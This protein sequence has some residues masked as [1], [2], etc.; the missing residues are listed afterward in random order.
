MGSC[1]LR[2]QKWALDQWKWFGEA[3]SQ[4]VNEQGLRRCASFGSRTVYPRAFSLC[5]DLI[6][7][8]GASVSSLCTNRD[9]LNSP[10]KGSYNQSHSPLPGE[11]QGVSFLKTAVRRFMKKATTLIAVTNPKSARQSLSPSSATHSRCPQ[12][13]VAFHLVW[14]VFWWGDSD[15]HSQSADALVALPLLVVV[16]REEKKRRRSV[17]SDLCT[18]MDYSPP[19]YSVHGFSR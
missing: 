5:T 17:V 15:L 16:R 11:G 7:Q 4:G 10:S 9:I 12:F 3:G 19:G 13:H 6:F 14:I 1:Q 18:P 2:S 8:D